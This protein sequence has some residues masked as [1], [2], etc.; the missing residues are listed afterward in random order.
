MKAY[1]V[2]ILLVAVWTATSI[3]IGYTLHPDAGWDIQE[4]PRACTIMWD[5][6]TYSYKGR[7]IHLGDLEPG[8]SK[9]IDLW[10]N[11]FVN[12]ENWPGHIHH[13]TISNPNS[14][15]RIKHD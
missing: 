4:D 6:G 14:H 13:N 3:W 12:T 9:K 5:D 10:N 8:E 11:T 1:I 7:T 15:Y 2:V